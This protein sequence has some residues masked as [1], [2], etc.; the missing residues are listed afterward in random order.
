MNSKEYIGTH[1]TKDLNNDTYLGS[2][3][4]LKLAIKKYGKDKFIRTILYEYKTSEEAYTKEKELVTQEYVD[5][6][7]LLYTSPSPRD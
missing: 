4:L 3:K 2:G 6:P 1:S 7:C 5:R